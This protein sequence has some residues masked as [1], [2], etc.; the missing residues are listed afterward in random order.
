VA[1]LDGQVVGLA[2]L[3][4]RGDEG[5][6]EPVVVSANHRSHGI[7][8]AL[9]QH[10]IGQAKLLGVRYLTVRPVARNREAIAFF[11]G[12]GFNVLGQVDLFQVVSGP[13]DA[14]WKSGISIH[15]QDLRY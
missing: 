15:G 3:L 6:V 13:A 14:R 2:G 7:G 10:V 4:V 12:L 8:R 5:Q 1:E 9:V 11:A